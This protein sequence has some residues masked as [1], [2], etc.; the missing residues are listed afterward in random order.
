MLETKIVIADPNTHQRLGEGEVGE[1]W[2]GS[3]SVTHGYWNQPELSEQTFRARLTDGDGPFLRTGDLGF[4][5]NGELFVTGRIKD[6]IIIRGRNLSPQDIEQTVE[7]CDP[8]IRPAFVAA[9]SV[10]SGGAERLVILAEVRR[11]ARNA[12]D[13]IALIERIRGAVAAEYQVEVSAVSLLKPNDLPKTSSGKTQRALAKKQFA[14]GALDPLIEWRDAKAFRERRRHSIAWS[15]GSC[16][17]L[18]P[19]RR[20][21]CSGST[22]RAPCRHTASTPSS[23]C[24]FWSDRAGVRDRSRCGDAAER[25]SILRQIVRRIQGLPDV[26]PPKIAVERTPPGG[27]RQRRRSL[28]CHRS[29]VRAD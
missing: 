11:E 27:A 25:R 20:C 29:T 4:L 28:G 26:E 21:R 24:R 22:W 12:I 15:R 1:I 13:K 8:A 10:E 18:R 17:G 5:M 19:R 2:L 6:L 7:A 14:D 9:V 3:E 23:C 16:S